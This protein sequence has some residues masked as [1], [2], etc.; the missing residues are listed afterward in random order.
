MFL[1]LNDFPQPSSVEHPNN[2]W[3]RLQI[4]YHLFMHFYFF[5]RLLVFDR[6]DN[7]SQ[8]PALQTPS[9]YALPLA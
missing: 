8:H 5:V 9:I 4:M 7:S 3:W 6:S 1:P 2:T